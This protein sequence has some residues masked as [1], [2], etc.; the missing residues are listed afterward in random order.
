MEAGTALRAA[1]LTCRTRKRWPS[2]PCNLVGRGQVTSKGLWTL[3][4]PSLH[5]RGQA[6]ERSGPKRK[7]SSN[8]ARRRHSR[9]FRRGVLIIG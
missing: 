1:L 4:C 5:T 2:S 8:R 9:C 6:T 3:E 7:S